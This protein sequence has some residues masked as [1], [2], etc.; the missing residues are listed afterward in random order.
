M[1]NLHITEKHNDKMQGMQSLSTCALCNENCA[2]NRNIKGS[3][4]EHCF[5]V[6]MEKRY[7]NLTQALIKNGEILSKEILPIDE[8]PTINACF[9]RFESFG[10]L[11][12]TN[13]L[14]NYINI[15]KK[16]P[17]V[18]FALWTKHFMIAETVFEKMGIEKP[19]NLRVIASSLM[20][21]TPIKK[22]CWADVTF[23]VWS[24]EEKAKENGKTINCGSKKCINCLACYVN[25]GITEINELIKSKQGKRQ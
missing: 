25:A 22:P 16:N 9:F 13:H 21:D 4:C 19:E 23:T 3:I 8:L 24:S 12:N 14:I 11:I 15:C 18:H 6:S 20:M 17:Y 10:D 2:K 5:A 1:A 7:N